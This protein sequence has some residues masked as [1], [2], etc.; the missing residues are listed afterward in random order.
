MYRGLVKSPRGA[1]A[2]E[3]GEGIT[4]SA[5]RKAAV[6]DTRERRIARDSPR[7]RTSSG[8]GLLAMPLDMLWVRRAWK[9]RVATPLR[10]LVKPETRVEVDGDALLVDLRDTVISRYLYIEQSYEEG[11]RRFMRCIDLAGL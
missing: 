5:G 1:R 11:L 10:V 9:R 6:G 8:R 3:H 2:A 4:W 7:S